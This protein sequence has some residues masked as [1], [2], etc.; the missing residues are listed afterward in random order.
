MN[1]KGYTARI[2]VDTEAG[3]IHGEVLGIRDVLTFQATS[4]D[5]LEQAFRATL[6]D[7]LEFCEKR[8][9]ES[10]KPLAGTSRVSLDPDEQ[11]V[12]QMRTAER[13][14]KKRKNMLGTLAKT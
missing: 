12:E 11:S 7:Y 13:I 8:G 14:M 3:I 1:Y 10:E 9:E 2:E 4:V 6:D 5:E